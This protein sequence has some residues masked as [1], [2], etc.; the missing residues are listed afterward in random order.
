MS[1]DPNK[2][3]R[4]TTRLRGY[5]YASPGTYFV[6]LN[7]QNRL[8][9]FGEIVN[10]SVQLNMYGKLAF[11]CWEQ[12]PTHFPYVHLDEFIIMPNHV[13]GIL[14][15]LKDPIESVGTRHAVSRRDP[16][17]LFGNPISGALSTIIRSF[18]SETT[19]KIN[20]LRGSPGEI[21]W[22]RRF[23]DHIIRNDTALNNIREY[24]LKNPAKWQWDREN[25]E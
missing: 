4:Q 7:A 6:T 21:V 9:L 12:I 8:H 5:D 17:E 13:H 16:K 11:D 15:I 2:H 14:Q 22:Q 18:K 24:I 3:H 10:G 19:R 25:S 23:H 1:Y 20:L